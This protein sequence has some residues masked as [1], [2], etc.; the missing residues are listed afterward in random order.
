MARVSSLR[1][2]ILKRQRRVDDLVKA[3]GSPVEQTRSR[4]A[5]ALGEL[6]DPIALEPL[7]AALDDASLQVRSQAARALGEIGADEAMGPLLEATWKHSFLENTAGFAIRRIG[8]LPAD[9]IVRAW[10][11]VWEGY[12]GDRWEMFEAVATL[13]KSGVP[14]SAPRVA[15]AIGRLRE[16]AHFE[17]RTYSVWES[18][19]DDELHD[20]RPRVAQKTQS[21]AAT[22]NRA[23]QL[24]KDM[25]V[26]VD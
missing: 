4:A 9:P 3:L 10:S 1:V 8:R 11:L 13:V 7:M 12:R 5:Q 19:D 23:R 17:D 25:G 2:A 16:L 22:R 20:R 15:T 6:K 26:A 14:V 24:L 21:H 18:V